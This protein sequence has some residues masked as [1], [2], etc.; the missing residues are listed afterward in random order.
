[1]L[2]VPEAEVRIDC[3]YYTGEI[4][5]LCMDKPIYDVILGNIPGVRQPGDPDITWKLKLSNQL[6][7]CTD[8]HRLTL[9]RTS[10][11][12]QFRQDHRRSLKVRNYKS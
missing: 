2:K 7:E 9:T 12:K 5:A 1:V 6:S 8:M 4:M 10:M 11:F 3:P